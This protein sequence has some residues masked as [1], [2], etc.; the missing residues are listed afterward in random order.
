MKLPNTLN[1]ELPFGI[2]LPEVNSLH[3]TFNQH[4]SNYET[5]EEMEFSM[6]RTRGTFG[7]ASDEE[8]S[9]A[10][11]N[12]SLWTA[13]LYNLTPVGCYQVAASSLEAVL[14]ALVS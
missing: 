14:R 2:T 11:A 10:I 9:K 7:W 3:I 8:R 5:I 13:Q 12:N 6:G 1:L 4:M